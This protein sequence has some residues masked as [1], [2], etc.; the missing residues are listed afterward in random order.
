M[1][2]DRLCRG[3]NRRRLIEMKKCVLTVVGI[4]MSL[5]H[6]FHY[7]LVVVGQ[8]YIVIP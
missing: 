3:I 6:Y 2:Y 1:I 4:D 7:L 5:L 8:V